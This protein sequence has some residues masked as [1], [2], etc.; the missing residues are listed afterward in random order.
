M[1]Q[2]IEIVSQEVFLNPP[3]DIF[4]KHLVLPE[5]NHGLP[6]ERRGEREWGGEEGEVMEEVDEEC[7][8]Q[9]YPHSYT[10]L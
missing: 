1:P 10:C 5:E 9:L 6:P 4:W 8:P 2:V 3:N 7:Q